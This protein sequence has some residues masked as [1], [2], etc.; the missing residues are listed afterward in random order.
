MQTQYWIDLPETLK[1][2]GFIYHICASG[3]VTMNDWVKLGHLEECLEIGS[4]LWQI[5]EWAD[6]IDSTPS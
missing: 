4:R 1:L 6:S 5:L 3:Y 2:G